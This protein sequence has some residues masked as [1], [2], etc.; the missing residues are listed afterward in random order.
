MKILRK[1]LPGLIVLL[2]VT[3]SVLAMSSANFGLDWHTALMGSGGA[4]QSGQYAVNVTVGQSAI[5][6]AQGSNY[7]VGMGYWSGLLPNF[8]LYLPVIRR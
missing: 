2:L 6:A 7:R 1:L 5:S 4:S 8:P 3:T